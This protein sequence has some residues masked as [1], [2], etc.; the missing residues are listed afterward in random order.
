MP[1][2]I[3]SCNDSFVPR[4]VRFHISI[5]SLYWA[6]ARPAKPTYPEACPAG[7]PGRSRKGRR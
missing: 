5:N 2:E 6:L 4:N 3:Q 7:R 1:C